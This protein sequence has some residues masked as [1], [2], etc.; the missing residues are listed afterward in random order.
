[1]GQGD[2][3]QQP[4]QNQDLIKPRRLLP[5]LLLLSATAVAQ[6]DISVVPLRYRS[7]VDVIPV[8]QPLLAPGGT[9]T[10]M[11][12]QL[13]I[14]TTP[15]N[16]AELMAVLE[17]VD[18]RLR[19][20]QISVRNDRSA[21]G[22][23]TDQSLAARYA[24]DNVAVAAGRDDGRHRGVGVGVDSSGASVRLRQHEQEQQLDDDSTFRLQTVD[25]QA[26]FV[27][28]GQSVP[29]PQRPVS[30]GHGT[31]V[32]QDGLEYRDAVSGFWVLPRLSGDQ[33]TLLVSPYM[34]GVR[35]GPG[36]VFEIQNAS[37]TV[38]GRLGQWLDIG[39]IDRSEARSTRE[40]GT[41]DSFRQQDATV[42][43]IRVDEIR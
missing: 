8:L 9:L 28:T 24:D 12:N 10:G 42:I 20:L 18:Q 16:H 41:A 21:H 26:A 22:V 14:K 1:M 30:A 33:V 38:S 11:D 29:V 31:V 15:E 27:E 4:A 39:G 23:R 43:R 5:V 19:R 13:V 34:S 17:R 3:R 37:T 35:A 32:A 6:M 36:P 7:A 2:H 25:G 40:I